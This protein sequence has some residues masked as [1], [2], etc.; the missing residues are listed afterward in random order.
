MAVS[1]E[2]LNSLTSVFTTTRE[3]PELIQPGQSVTLKLLPANPKLTATDILPGRID[4]T[5]ITKDVRF[6]S[7]A[8]ESVFSATDFTPGNINSLLKGGMP[9]ILPTV[10]PIPGVNAVGTQLL[11]GVP[12]MLAQLGGNLPIPVEVPVSVSVKWDVLDAD[13]ITVLKESEGA[14]QA[15]T[16]LESAELVLK[17]PIETTELTN[18]GLI[19][20]KQRFI[21]ASVI[22]KAGTTTLPPFMLP[23]IP[24]LVAA[25]PVPTLAAFFLHADFA[26]M[27]G[28]DDAGAVLI[29]VPENSPL[30]ELGHLQPVLDTLQSTLSTVGATGDLAALLLGVSELKTALAAQPHVQFRVA[31]DNDFDN[32]DE[33]T[34][35]SGT[36]NDTEAEDELSSLIFIGPN[37]KE[38]HCFVARSQNANEGHFKLTLGSRLHAMVRNLH[39]K[40]PVSEPDGAIAVLVDPEGGVLQADTFG[41]TLSSLRFV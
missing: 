29:V 9:T 1:T 7:H 35:K 5:W 13:G 40:K 37:N 25:I 4:L 20:T 36:I 19:P 18:S 8:V 33:V 6:A 2:V 15:S 28:E 16:G 38:L 31:M 22:L 24:V 41:D 27:R 11:E 34:L 10:T 39:F 30:R 3:G 14:F 21:R 12:G 17:F 26:P 23:K 32:L